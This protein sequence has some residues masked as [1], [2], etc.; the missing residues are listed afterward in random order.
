MCFGSVAVA[1]TMGIEVTRS[2]LPAAGVALD[3]ASAVEDLLKRYVTGDRSSRVQEP[4]IHEHRRHFRRRVRPLHPSFFSGRDRSPDAIESLANGAF[5][6]FSEEPTHEGR[7]AFRYAVEKRFSPPTGFLY[8]WRASATILFL[9]REGSALLRA[10]ANIQ[11]NVRRH[12]QEACEPVQRAGEERWALPHWD[13]RQRQANPP[14][15]DGVSVDLASA[16]RGRALI[17]A[18]LKAA[19]APLSRAEISAIIERSSGFLNEVNEPEGLIAS[20]DAFNELIEARV[21]RAQLQRA[22]RRFVDQLSDEERQ[23]MRDRG[24][25][26][27]GGKQKSFRTIAKERPG[28]GAETYRKMERRIL[29]ALP[30]AFEPEE[31][32]TAIELV[33]EALSEGPS[34]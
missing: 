18:V 13:E 5:A 16:G 17:T 8:Y 28:R 24:Y 22:A 34:Q 12:V 7:P 27:T 2:C 29:E 20:L 14:P 25:T 21:T 9:R 32:T 3:S 15:I 33:V 30:N 6:S 11:R 19:G 1:Q 23:L 10:R 26:T 31:I 4:L